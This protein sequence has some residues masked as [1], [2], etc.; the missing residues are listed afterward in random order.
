MF[1]KT[2]ARPVAPHSLLLSCTRVP[3]H[4]ADAPDAC[5][6]DDPLAN[7][8]PSSQY[9][10]LVGSVDGD[11]RLMQGKIFRGQSPPRSARADQGGEADRHDASFEVYSVRSVPVPPSYFARYARRVILL[12]SG[13]IQFVGE[14]DE[15]GVVQA[16]QPVTPA[17]NFVEVRSGAGTG[18]P[19]TPGRGGSDGA[20]G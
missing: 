19:L 5:T 20:L 4:P 16:A 15:C 11:L 9:L 13:F 6:N 3:S 8:D 2:Y 7:E 1:G 17:D 10:S 18:C 14:D 12:S